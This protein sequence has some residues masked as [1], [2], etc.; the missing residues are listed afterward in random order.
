MWLAKSML[1]SGQGSQYPG[2]TVL[3]LL[4]LSEQFQKPVSRCLLGKIIRPD[5]I[6][7]K[8]QGIIVF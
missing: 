3:G 2:D 4:H 8:N 1:F 7:R 5:A 6:E